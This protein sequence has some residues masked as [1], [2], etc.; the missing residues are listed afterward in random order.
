MIVHIYQISPG[1]ELNI[2]ISIV[3]LIWLE[4]KNGD[5]MQKFLEVL[6]HFDRYL[7][8]RALKKSLPRR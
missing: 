7:L 3:C 4:E 6:N 8:D 2:T 1:F 5:I